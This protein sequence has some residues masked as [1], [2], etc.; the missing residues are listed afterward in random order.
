M[1]ILVSENKT[2]L[3]ILINLKFHFVFLGTNPNYTYN[4]P[5]TRTVKVRLANKL[6]NSHSSYHS[7][8]GSFCAIAL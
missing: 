2:D 1:I 4:T 3:E 7:V 6:Q 8:C 5:K